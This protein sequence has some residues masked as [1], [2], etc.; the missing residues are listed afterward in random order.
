MTKGDTYRV[1]RR[2]HVDAPPAVVHERVVDLHRWT[3]WSPWEDLD[4]DQ[5]RRYGG[6]EQG[7]GAWYAW[8]GNR[9][10]GQG[11]MEIVGADESTVTIDLQFVK[12]FKSRS[13]TAFELRPDGDGTLVTWTMTGPNTAML[14]LMGLF[15]SMDK[16][17]GPDFEKGLQRLKADA[18]AADGSTPSAT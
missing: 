13:T 12:P 9:K 11:R 16:L 2:I 7:V 14:R 1:E 17:I 18:E 10:A 5:E 15:T 4:P 8:R 6:A 3:S